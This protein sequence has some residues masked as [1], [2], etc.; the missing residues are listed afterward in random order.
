MQIDYESEYNARRRVP[1]H[2]EIMACW[3]AQSERAR[4]TLAC[5]LDIP[6]GA[7]PR[8]RYDLFLPA[9][10]ASAAPV[11]VYIHGGYW[12]RGDRREYSF[13]AN[14]LTARGAIVAL[15]SYTLCPQV[16]VADIVE[17][18]RQFVLTLWARLGRRPAV[19]G[20][21][22]G[23]HLAAALLATDWAQRAG[24]P[25]DLVRASYAI[26]GLFELAPLIPTSLNEALRLTPSSARAASPILWPP[27]PSGRRLV[28]AVGGAESGEFMRQSAAL[29][30]TWSAAGLDARRVVVPGGNHFTV[31]DAL[32]FPDSTMVDEVLDMACV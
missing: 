27:P 6:Y 3:A 31:L 21:S 10:D 23:G 16:T 22:A 30:A 19:V 9:R 25:A 11:V 7:G 17:E 26:S 32:S 12:Q 13:V 29:A 18:M 28:A 1:D 14:A 15:P 5:E 4:A 24:A 20:H 8:Q 2:P